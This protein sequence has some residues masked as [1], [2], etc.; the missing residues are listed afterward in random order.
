MAALDQWAEE[1]QELQP[2]LGGCR[3]TQDLLGL[4]L[5]QP[6]LQSSLQDSDVDVPLKFKK[7]VF[8]L[9]S[10]E[11]KKTKTLICV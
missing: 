1:N 8:F 11:E 6:G 3:M 4:L 7:A 10:F 9:C 2:L 5:C